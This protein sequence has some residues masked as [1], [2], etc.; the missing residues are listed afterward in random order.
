MTAKNWYVIYT[1]PRNEK[2]VA[3]RLSISGFET[4]CPLVK[5]LKVWS[6]RK[7]KVSMPMFPSYVFIRITEKERYEV[8]KDPGVMNFVFWLGKPAVVRDIEIEAIR[9][10]AEYSEDVEVSRLQLE[11][12]QLLKIS[13]GPFKG[14][15]GKVTDISKNIVMVYIEQLGFQI[16]FKYSKRHLI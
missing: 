16:Q 14:L 11:K 15:T 3:E 8:L 10:I 2:K 7:K 13:D 12:G 9:E 1:K 4:Y 6:D 5:T